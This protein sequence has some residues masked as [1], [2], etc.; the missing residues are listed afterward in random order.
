[1]P[2]LEE[3]MQEWYIEITTIIVLLSSTLARYLIDLLS[4]QP[5]QKQTVTF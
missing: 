5:D 3:Q 1:M 4:L 2:W